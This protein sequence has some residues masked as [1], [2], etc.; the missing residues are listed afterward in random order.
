MHTLVLVDELGD[1]KECGEH[2]QSEGE[3]EVCGH[4]DVH[5][6]DQKGV[7]DPTTTEIGNIHFV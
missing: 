3:L 4:L 5:E 2:K 6:A 1:R 7:G